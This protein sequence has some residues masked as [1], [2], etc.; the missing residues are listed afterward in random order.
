MKIKDKLVKELA[1]K[2]GVDPRIVRLIVDY[3]IKFS[4]D[5]I[6]D[7]EDMRPIRIRYFGVFLPKTKY[8]KTHREEV[9]D[10]SRHI[11]PDPKS[12]TNK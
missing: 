5:K 7:P 9:P 12:S 4:R 2:Y 3:P 10:P 1:E 11:L 8:E 6:S